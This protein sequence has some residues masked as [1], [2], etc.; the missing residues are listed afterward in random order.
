MDRFIDFVQVA[1][2]DSYV[3]LWSEDPLGFDGDG[4][5][6]TS[7]INHANHTITICRFVVPLYALDREIKAAQ[8]DAIETYPRRR[9]PL[10]VVDVDCR[11]EHP[12]YP[13]E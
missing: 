1:D 2:D 10:R 4:D 11:F 6:I 9:P 3:A 13:L 8:R 7:Q 5:A 12:D